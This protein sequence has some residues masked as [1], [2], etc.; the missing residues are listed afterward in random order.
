MCRRKQQLCKEVGQGNNGAGT[1]GG[2]SSDRCCSS[3]ECEK[4]Q[5]LVVLQAF[6]LLLLQQGLKAHN[7]LAAMFVG[8][9]WSAV[10]ASAKR[11]E[12]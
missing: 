6:A 3:A 8:Y 11:A 2:D 10:N 1:V 7:S 5:N 9:Q 12:A 4:G